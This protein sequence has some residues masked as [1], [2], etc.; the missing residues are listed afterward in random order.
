[1]IE[2]IVLT[3]NNRSIG[4][5]HG[6][7]LRKEIHA[8]YE[9]YREI[10]KL[11]DDQITLRLGG[12]KQAIAMQLPRFKEEIEG[13][14]K[15]AGVHEQAI[16]A[17]NCRTELL[18]DQSL[19][20]CT[21]AGIASFAKGG[22]QTVLAQNWDWVNTLRGLTKVVQINYE[23]GMKLKMLIE[24]GMV[25]KIGL[26]SYGLG[27]CLNFLPTK[28]GAVGVPVHIILRGILEC[29]SSEDAKAFVSKMPRA[30]SANYLFGDIEDGI[31]SLETTPDRIIVFQL[32]NGLLTHTNAY[33]GEGEVC[34]RQ[35]LFEK[36][37]RKSLEKHGKIPPEKLKEA[38]ALDGVCVPMSGVK[39]GI[40]TIHTIIM[41]LNEGKML[42]SEGSSS[43]AFQKFYLHS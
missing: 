17:I 5:Q 33:N 12:I 21:A 26:N 1:M 3:G 24:P 41:N 43:G 22:C 25:G 2:E 7:H 28:H 36:S 32:G 9:V 13:I 27:T 14:A 8:T 34:S 19:L 6:A 23:T 29:E 35:Q 20:E 10:W 39:G 38:L 42:I 31:F 4:E 37:L 16:Y 11:S 30:S 18:S 15:G 40:E